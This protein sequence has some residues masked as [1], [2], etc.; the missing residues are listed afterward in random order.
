LRFVAVDAGAD[1]REGLRHLKWDLVW[2]IK[3]NYLQ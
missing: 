2:V 1:A 3:K